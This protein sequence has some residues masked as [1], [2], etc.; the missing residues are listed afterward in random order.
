MAMDQYR[1]MSSG[2]S[3]G[4]N[5][6][7]SPQDSGLHPVDTPNGGR[8]PDMSSNWVQSRYEGRSI[9]RFKG[10]SAPNQTPM[11]NVS[12]QNREDTP[13]GG[14]QSGRPR[15]MAQNRLQNTKLTAPSAGGSGKRP[16][17][18]DL[19]SPDGMSV[20]K[21]HDAKIHPKRKLAIAMRKWWSNLFW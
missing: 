8:K 1:Q 19:N 20:S 5:N 9:N 18:A 14:R 10:F 17:T 11:A 12:G 16:R 4:S 15:N 13:A 21:R 2:K 6:P 7:P 3:G